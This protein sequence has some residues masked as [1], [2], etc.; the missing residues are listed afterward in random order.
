MYP[1]PVYT[2]SVQKHQNLQNTRIS[3]YS[4]IYG[5]SRDIVD[6]SC[7]TKTGYRDIPDYGG[8]RTYLGVYRRDVLYI[9]DM[10]DMPYSDI[11]HV[12]LPR[13]SRD[14]TISR[15]SRDIDD[16]S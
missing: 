7:C 1:D 12:C 14:I 11:A 13:Q 6:I 2:G 5:V 10:A 9:P 16:I 8:I 4:E 3:G 15:E